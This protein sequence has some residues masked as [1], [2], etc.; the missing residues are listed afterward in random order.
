MTFVEAHQI[1]GY[2]CDRGHI[3]PWWALPAPLPKPRRS[4]DR[5]RIPPVVVVRP[6]P[7]CGRAL[8]G[9]P[10]YQLAGGINGCQL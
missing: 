3:G 9:R 1:Y 2:S 6:V 8:T 5:G 10:T 4:P 7:R